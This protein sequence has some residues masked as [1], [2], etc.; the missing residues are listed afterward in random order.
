MNSNSKDLEGDIRKK[1]SDR[2]RGIRNKKK[3][4]NKLQM[5]NGVCFYLYDKGHLDAKD[6]HHIIKTY[7]IFMEWYDI[8]SEK[9]IVEACVR[10]QEDF[11]SFMYWFISN[12]PRPQSKVDNQ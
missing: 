1:L 11:K 2:R 5:M 10:I 3:K 6:Q 9:H 4:F 12:H 7:V 8:P